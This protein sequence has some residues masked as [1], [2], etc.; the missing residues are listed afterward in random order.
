MPHTIS[1]AAVLSA[2]IG[3]A[4]LLSCSDSPDPTATSPTTSTVAQALS[5]PT[6]QQQQSGTLNRLQ[7]I[8][9]VN[10][11]IAWASG[12]GGTYTV[13]RN[14]GATWKA[15][16][17]PGAETLEFRDV[18]GI[19]G[20]EAYLL[21]AGTGTDARVYHTVDGGKTWELQ[22]K[23]RDDAKFFDCFAFWN[24]TR[25][26]VMVDAVNGRLP[27]HR[28]TNGRFW[29]DI[30]NKLPPAQA[31]EAAFASSGTCVA[32]QGDANGW[33]G[34]GGA[35]KA[36]ILATTDGGNSWQSYST[37]DRPRHVVGGHLH[38]GIP[39]RDARHPGWR[40]PGAEHPDSQRRGLERRRKD[41]DRGHQRAVQGGGLRVEL[42]L[43]RT[44]KVPT[45]RAS[46]SRAPVGRPG[47]RTKAGPGTGWP[48]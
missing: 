37:P 41:L 17:V 30:G 15:G 11:Q 25:A 48:A 45:T 5:A 24:S 12:T 4:L 10:A 34:T 29:Q 40:G 21:S 22:F 16:V 44:T 32:T 1:A 47:P 2:S 42:H 8:S 20:Q 46:W 19:S 26:L 31:G 13:T 7:A 36:R 27:V 33:I 14:G 38:R 18:E 39:R 43:R 9:P 35:E 3:T 6:L 28:T 23:N